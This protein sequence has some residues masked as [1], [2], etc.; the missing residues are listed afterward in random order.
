[1]PKIAVDYSNTIIY[2]LYCKDDNVKDV[3]V[4]HTT[5]F[6]KRKW[7]HKNNAMNPK[8]SNLKIYK[9]IRANGG[10]SN[11]NMV[12]IAKYK[13]SNA[14]EAKMK[15]IK[16][17][18]EEEKTNR[19]K[20]IEPEYEDYEPM[21]K[22][23]YICHNCD[24]CYKTASGLWKHSQLCIETKSEPGD[25][26]LI[27][28]LIKEN[29]EMKN[30]MMEVIKNGTHNTTNSNNTNNINTTNNNNTNNTFNLQFF[31][32]ETCKDAINMSEF[33]DSIELQIQDLEE[34]GRLGYVDGISKVVIRKLNALNE[35]DRPIHCSDSKREIIYI[36]DDECWSK[37]TENK[38]KIKTM[39]KH[40]AHKN[41]KQIPEWVK[42]HPNCYESD[43]IHNDKYLKIVSNSMSGS[44]EEEQRSNLNKIISKV[45]KEVVIRK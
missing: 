8:A 1:M 30:M 15:E 33:I 6:S 19:S 3:Y 41:I 11:W 37:D 31:L 18:Q 22:K 7:K 20:L 39:I 13:C 35:H 23:N 12:E 21:A 43:S 10:W 2:K 14:A 27:M 38:D 16:H 29:S 36:K 25:K 4:G 44:T 9:I 42:K 32:N 40:V 34:T 28:M 26:D 17:S 45:V 5:N 24:K